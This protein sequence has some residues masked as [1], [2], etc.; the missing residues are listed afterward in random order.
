MENPKFEAR[1]PKQIRMTKIRNSKQIQIQM[2]VL[3][4]ESMFLAV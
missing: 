2:Q 3:M 4:Y 1:N